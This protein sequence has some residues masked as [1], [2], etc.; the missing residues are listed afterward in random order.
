MS[1][2]C[3]EVG[4]GCSSVPRVRVK[5]AMISNHSISALIVILKPD[6]ILHKYAYVIGRLVD[7]RLV[8]TCLAILITGTYDYFHEHKF[9]LQTFLID[10]IKERCI[11][12]Y[13]HDQC[14]R[15]SQIGAMNMTLLYIIDE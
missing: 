4:G 6:I 15:T 13:E 2:S 14:T 5:D 11:G 3:Y 8:T 9:I 12:R 10:V 1:D 7:N